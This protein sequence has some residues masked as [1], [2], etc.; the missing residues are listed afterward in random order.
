MDNASQKTPAQIQKLLRAIW[1][2]ER[3]EGFASVLIGVTGDRQV[4]GFLAKFKDQA[5][6]DHYLPLNDSSE[7]RLARL[8][9]FMSRSIHVVSSSLANGSSANAI[10]LVL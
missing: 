7:D 10:P 8:A 1:K 3:L 4:N 9:G 2:E 6:L 5:G